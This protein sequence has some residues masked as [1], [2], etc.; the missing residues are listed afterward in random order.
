MRAGTRGDRIP[1]AHPP[2]VPQP[3][4][5]L[6]A[7]LGLDRLPGGPVRTSERAGVPRPATRTEAKRRAG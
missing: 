6:L 3:T 7:E 2:D 4:D 5:E 1:V